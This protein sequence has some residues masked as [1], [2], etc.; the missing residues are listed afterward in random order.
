MDGGMGRIGQGKAPGFGDGLLAGLPIALGYLPIAFSFGVAATQAGMAPVE[1][2]A[3]SLA[4]YAGASQFLALALLASGAPILVAAGTLV[5]MNVRHVLYGPALLRA[6]GVERTRAG[7]AWGAGLTDE[8][9]GA[10]LGRFGRGGAFSERFMGG[11]AL[12]A[13]AAWVGGTAAGA[14][15]GGGVLAGWPL[16]EAGLSFMLPA[17]FLAL[18][19]SI[20]DRAALPAVAVAVA[21]AVAATLLWSSTAGLICGMVAGAMTG[22]MRR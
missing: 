8:V 10:A 14:A 4:I 3:L 2:V 6:A 16:V 20:L 18:L 9:F 5:A 13:Y 22:V 17:L 11:L 12:L 1:A 19:L 7:W 15:A 21:A